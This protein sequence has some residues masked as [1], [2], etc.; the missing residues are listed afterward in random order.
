VPT[1]IGAGMMILLTSASTTVKVR[2]GHT[3]SASIK[4]V[5]MGSEAS[6]FRKSEEPVEPCFGS[7]AIQTLGAGHVVLKDGK[8]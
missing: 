5:R 7:T 3:E 8:D 4:T 6:S 1:V 2:Y